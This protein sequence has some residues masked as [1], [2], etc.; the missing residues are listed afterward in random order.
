MILGILG[1]EMFRIHLMRSS[2]S[3]SNQR[4]RRVPSHDHHDTHLSFSI[5]FVCNT[6]TATTIHDDFPLMSPLGRIT[7]ASFY[8]TQQMRILRRSHT[9]LLV[10]QLLVDRMFR[11]MRTRFKTNVQA[12]RCR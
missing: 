9:P 1:W 6:T 11:L 4:R 12:I 8:H 7:H 10:I 3:S 2:S 5:Q